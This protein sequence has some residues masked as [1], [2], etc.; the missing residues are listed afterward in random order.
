[1]EKTEPSGETVL[2]RFRLGL[3]DRRRDHALDRL[4]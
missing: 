2:A 1:M 4:L 3:R